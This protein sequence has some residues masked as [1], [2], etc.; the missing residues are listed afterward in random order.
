MSIISYLLWIPCGLA[1]GMVLAIQPYMTRYNSL[2]AVAF[3]IA[4][5]SLTLVP[6]AE[7]YLA[8]GVSALVAYALLWRL[9]VVEKYQRE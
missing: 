4:V 2:C 6:P 5:C 9:G 3:A 8:W 1:V 7:A